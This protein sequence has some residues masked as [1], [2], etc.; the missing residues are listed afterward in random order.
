MKKIFLLL[1]LS[2]LSIFTYAQSA[3]D[4]IGKWMSSSGEAHIQIY[5]KGNIYSGK[6]VWLKNPKHENGKPKLDE[7]NP[8][9]S[10]KS[11]PIL[12]LEIVKDLKFNNEF[13]E[14]GT[15]YDPQSGKNYNS[16]ITLK[17]SNQLSLRGYIGLSLIGRS[18][19]WTKV[20]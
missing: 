3:D 8:N 5:K 2:I 4:I 13:W 6:I 14:N 15:I 16:K 19:I 10:L 11:R 7:N 12:G 9:T 1:I 20:K 17:G 18:E